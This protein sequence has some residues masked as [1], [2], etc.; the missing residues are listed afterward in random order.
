MSCVKLRILD[1]TPEILSRAEVFNLCT[2]LT[3]LKV[4]MAFSDAGA[5]KARVGV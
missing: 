1:S 5:E 2:N 4:S 3:T